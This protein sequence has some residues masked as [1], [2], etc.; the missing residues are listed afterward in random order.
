RPGRTATLVEFAERWK[1]EV[2]SQRKPS[3][4]RAAG[5]HLGRYILRELGSLRLDQLTLE[6]QQAFV[7]SLSK[8]LSRKSILNVASTLSAVLS[9]ARAWGYLTEGM[10]L[11]RLSLPPRN[12]RPQRRFFTAQEVRQVVQAAPEPYST[13]YMLA[14]MSGMRSGEIFGLKVEDLD[15]ERG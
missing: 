13:I 2:L 11:K 8:R 14:A 3:T 10:S 12:E 15:F 1:H 9:A 6:T 7:A 5:V 4:Q